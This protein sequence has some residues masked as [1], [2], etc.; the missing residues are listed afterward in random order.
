[1]DHDLKLPTISIQG[2][3]PLF[4]RRSLKIEELLNFM[5][6]NLKYTIDIKAVQKR[7]YKYSVFLPFHL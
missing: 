1:M 5:E 2:N 6:F 7:K 3:R 4:P